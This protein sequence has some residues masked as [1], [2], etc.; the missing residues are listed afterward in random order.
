MLRFRPTRT[1]PWIGTLTGVTAFAILGIALRLGRF[2]LR[3][4]LWC[5]EAFVAANFIDH[6]YSD[7][8]G[9]LEY[10]QIV[11]LLFLWAQLS[12]VKLLG[13]SEYTLR[14]VPTLA[15]LASVPLFVY[16]ARRVFHGRALLLAVAI[17]CVAY[18]PIRH[19][20][21]CK[22][23]AT[24]LFT[25]LVLITLAVRIAQD[26]AQ[27]RW[28]FLLCALVPLAIGFSHPA[29]FVAGGLTLALAP[30]AWQQRRQLGPFFVAYNV[31]MLAAF[32]VVFTLSSRAQY[33]TEATSLFD[34][35][36]T[37]FPPSP[38]HPLAWLK[39]FWQAHAGFL[40]AYPVGGKNG[41]SI[42]SFLAILIACIGLIRR[43]RAQLVAILLAPAAVGILAA[44]LH[45]YPY[46]GSTRVVLYLAPSMCLLAGWGAAWVSIKLGLLITR[47]RT[48]WNAHTIQAQIQVAALA[49][50][51]VIGIAGG[52]RDLI[53]PYKTIWDL[54]DQ[55]FARWL[56]RDK[57]HDAELV[58]V[59]TDLGW[60]LYPGNFEWGHSAQYVCN[61]HIYSQR[62]HLGQ[63]APW[64]Q[65]S[66]TRP[67]RCVLYSVPELTRDEAAYEKWLAKMHER[68]TLAAR[69]RH[70]VNGDSNLYHEVFELYDFVP[71]TDVIAD[72][73]VPPAQ[74]PR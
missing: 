67:L 52:M 54:N 6:D 61:Q 25:S 56:W 10:H 46:G 23:Y 11:P 13:F 74:P 71:R 2:L 60:D 8:L 9:P 28:Q 47:W 7:L 62:H 22:P 35:W 70:V 68:Y 31:L 41:A 36:A 40:C 29:V 50:L 16:L 30:L 4:P 39:W 49:I 26:P 15:S 72:Q 19:G 57:A 34:Y 37:G 53:Q 45:K 44:M 59:K 33:Q 55:G 43:G 69:E 21:E 58:C 65:V 17:F 38:L 27:R 1:A 14:L 51:L 63:S 12:V 18:Y 32:A 42:L 66:A 5:D 73:S 64:Q 3:F 20:A 48:N 24:D